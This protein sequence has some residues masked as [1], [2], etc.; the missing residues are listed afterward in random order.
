MTNRQNNPLT[1]SRLARLAGIGVETIRYYQRI[2][3][4]QTPAKPPQGYRIYPADTLKRLQFISR[5]KQLGFTLKEIAELLQL[6]PADCQTTRKLAQQKY[7][8]IQ[9][10]V[11][12]L[13]AISGIL[14]QLIERCDADSTDTCP[15]LA[16][17]SQPER[18]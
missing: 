12:D 5:A 16:A 8:D 2:G 9:A 15:I 6:G 17:L 11:R 18:D 1:I 4:L 13:Q 14:E 3:L 7:N 10:K